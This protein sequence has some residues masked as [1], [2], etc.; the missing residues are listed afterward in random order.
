MIP[1]SLV[2]ED[3]LTKAVAMTI[4]QGSGKVF[5]VNTVYESGGFGYIK[6]KIIGFNSAAKGCPYLVITD[7]DTGDCA[8]ELITDWFGRV[9]AQHN[10]IFRVA[11]REVESW[12]LADRERFSEF[13]GIRTN[14]IPDNTDTIADPKATLIQLTTRSRKRSLRDRIVPEPTVGAKQGPDYNGALIEFVQSRWRINIA[15]NHSPSL[16]RTYARIRDF[17]PVWDTQETN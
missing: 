15:V 1:I 7:L 14:L 12:I 17:T 2:V 13:L 11:V 16:N 3:L 10:L 9:T 5:S 6:S 8:P 4:L